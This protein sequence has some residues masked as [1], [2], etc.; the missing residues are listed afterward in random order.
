MPTGRLRVSTS[1]SVSHVG[2]SSSKPTNYPGNSLRAISSTFCSPLDTG[3]Q[4]LHK[5]SRR[6]LRPNLQPYDRFQKLNLVPTVRSSRVLSVMI[7][8]FSGHHLESER[9]FSHVSHLEVTSVTYQVRIVP[10]TKSL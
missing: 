8:D 10:E 6:T 7:T 9:P 3:Q 1:V 5:S 4:V 2:G